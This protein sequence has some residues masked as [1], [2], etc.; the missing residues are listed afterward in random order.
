M[1]DYCG[2]EQEDMWSFGFEN[3][4][5]QYC[6]EHFN[7]LCEKYGLKPGHEIEVTDDRYKE[8]SDMQEA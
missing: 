6:E 4:D 2:A 7:I 1:C 5:G 3:D 8:M